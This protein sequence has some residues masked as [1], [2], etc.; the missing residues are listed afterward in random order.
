MKKLTLFLLLFSIVIFGQKKS[1]IYE[2]KSKSTVDSLKVDSL[3]FYLDIDNKNSVFRSIQFRISDSLRVKRGYPNGYETKFDNKKLY[4]TKDRNTNK[5]LKFAFIPIAY[6][7]FALD[8]ND[9]INWQITQEKQNIG[10]YLCQKATCNY[11]GRN[12]VAWFTMDISISEGPYVFAG[13]PGMIVKIYDEGQ[14]FDFELVEV[15]NFEWKDLE[16][17]K[18]QK[19]IT[20]NDYEK[21]QKNFY[22][23]PTRTLKKGDVLNETTKGNYE[24]VNLDKFKKELQKAIKR[25]YDPLELNHKVEF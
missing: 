19:I 2:L 25:D 7:T 20:W 12:W 6:S 16:V 13:L 3:T 1:F 11:G 22:N 14:N 9:S 23:N 15:K 24:E 17:I 21:L 8:I 18:Y 10:N 4:T 5:I